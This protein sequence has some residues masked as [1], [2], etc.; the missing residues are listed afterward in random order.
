MKLLLTSAGVTNKSIHNALVE[1]LG[2]PIADSTA[3]CIPTAMYG[4]PWVGP[5]IKTWE[6]ISGNSENPMV[7][8]G[9]KSVGILELTAMPSIWPIGCANP[10]WQNSCRR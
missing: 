10:A 1:M 9:W 8:L 3:L 4:H 6:F 2:K 5:G 7:G